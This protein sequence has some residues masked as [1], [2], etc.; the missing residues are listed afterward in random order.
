MCAAEQ[1]LV[2]HVVLKYSATSPMP[3]MSGINS[4]TYIT[5]GNVTL[6]HMTIGVF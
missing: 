5:I 3:T 2:P 6:G 1:L 4:H